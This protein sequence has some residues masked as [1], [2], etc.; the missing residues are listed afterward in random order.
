[1][2]S[3]FTFLAKL[4]PIGD[5]PR[6]LG[7]F[8]KDEKAAQKIICKVHPIVVYKQRRREDIDN[9]QRLIG[10]SLD[11]EVFPYGS[12]QLKTYLPD[13]DINFSAFGKENLEDKFTDDLKNVVEGEER[14]K[15]TRFVVKG[16]QV[17]N[18]QVKLVRC[19]V[20]NIVVDI[21]FN[22][23]GDLC[24]LCFLEKVDLLI[25]KGHLFKHSIILIKARCYYESHILVAHHGL[26][27]T[28]ALETM[29]YIFHL[30]HSTLNDPLAVLF[31]YLD[32]VS[33]FDWENYCISL[34]GPVHI[35]SLPA[36]VAERKHKPL[37]KR[38]GPLEFNMVMA[39]ERHLRKSYL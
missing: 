33:K 16:V 15:A 9:V 18:A 25:G 32:Y 20:Q 17:I 2:T 12:V 31:K 1:M 13:G 14:N 39:R 29:L 6:T 38:N 30:I 34:S 35:Y 24:T 7:Q 19:I 36:I 21:S 28:Y 23:I 26:I 5:W 3:P 4:K 10:N 11:A 8:A 22:Q 27:S 37:P